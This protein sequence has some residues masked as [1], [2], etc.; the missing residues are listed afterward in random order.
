M[1]VSKLLFLHVKAW[2]FVYSPSSRRGLSERSEI[3]EL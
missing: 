1:K 3:L 2:G